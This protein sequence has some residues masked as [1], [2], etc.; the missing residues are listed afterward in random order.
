MAGLVRKDGKKKTSEILRKGKQYGSGAGDRVT[1][2]YNTCRHVKVPGINFGSTYS[3][4]IKG[5]RSMGCRVEAVPPM[6]TEAS[7]NSH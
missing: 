5:D 1:V 3:K 7:T 6:D 2:L 4:N